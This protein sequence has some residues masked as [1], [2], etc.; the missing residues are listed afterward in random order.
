MT[1]VNLDL[2]TSS[3]A[4]QISTVKINTFRFATVMLANIKAIC[5]Q[6]MQRLEIETQW[7]LVTLIG[8]RNS[9]FRFSILFMDM[10]EL[11]KCVISLHLL[12]IHF[13]SVSNHNQN[14]MEM[15]ENYFVNNVSIEI[16]VF[17]RDLNEKSQV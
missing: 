5:V 10:S 15:W 16:S 11:N 4:V 13:S 2:L 17:Q 14:H 1:S 9:I 8:Y 3:T 7:S 12:V 6:C